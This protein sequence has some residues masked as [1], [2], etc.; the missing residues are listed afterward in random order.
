[1]RREAQ[2]VKDVM[3]GL[4]RTGIAMSYVNNSRPV[5][6]SV[7]SQGSIVAWHEGRHCAHNRRETL[8]DFD[9]RISRI[10]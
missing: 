5:A 2:A 4:I 9:A 3:E 10:K 7:P 6:I 8:R 1:M